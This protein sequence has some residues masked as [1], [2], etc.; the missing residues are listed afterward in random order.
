MRRS[1]LAR[2]IV[3]AALTFSAAASA[4]TDRLVSPWAPCTTSA[5]HGV[6]GAYTFRGITNSNG[7][8]TYT[9]QD[10]WAAKPGTTQT[11]TS[12]APD[13][14]SVVSE[15]LPAGSKNV[16]TYPNVQQ[17]FNNWNGH[18]WN[19]RGAMADTPVFGLSSLTSSFTESMPHN[20]TTVA[21]AAYDI[22]LSQTP[23]A[24]SNEVMVWV[25][26]VNRGTGGDV[27]QIGSATINRQVFTVLQHGGSGGEIIFSLNRNEQKGT[28]DILHVMKWLIARGYEPPSVAIKQI[29]FGWEICSETTP[30]PGNTFTI[31]RYSINAS[32]TRVLQ[33]Q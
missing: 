16:Q 17:L 2:P 4:A 18:G 26:N 9:G 24:V 6:C 1:L 30:P 31:S 13:H 29:Q 22:W 8:N 12:M 15:A 10:M 3:V 5:T 33:P 25:D 14:W 19:G 21:E 27:Q 28:V 11:L 7:Y 32:H 20:S 23:K